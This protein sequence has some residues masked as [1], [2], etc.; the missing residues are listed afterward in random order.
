MYGTERDKEI[1]IDFLTELDKFAAKARE[2]GSV[3]VRMYGVADNEFRSRALERSAAVISPG[4]AILE[5]YLEDRGYQDL[6]AREEVLINDPDP[7]ERYS[8]FSFV[9]NGTGINQTARGNGFKDQSGY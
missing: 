4:L 7:R 5:Q 2:E 3:E 8:I 1:K 6:I 9:R